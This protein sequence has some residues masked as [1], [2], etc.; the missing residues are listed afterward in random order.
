MEVHVRERVKTLT[1]PRHSAPCNAIQVHFKIRLRVNFGLADTNCFQ[2]AFVH[3]DWLNFVESAS[4][5][6]TAHQWN[7]QQQVLHLVSHQV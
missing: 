6:S 1:Q 2:A 4:V 5:R 3:L 7:Y